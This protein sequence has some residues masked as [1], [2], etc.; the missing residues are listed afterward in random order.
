MPDVDESEP[1]LAAESSLLFVD[2][3]DGEDPEFDE[4]LAEEGSELNCWVSGS[5]SI[6]RGNNE[7]FALLICLIFPSSIRPSCI[8]VAVPARVA[9]KCKIG[10]GE[11]IRGE[12]RNGGV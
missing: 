10:A 2:E 12:R 7:R 11:A 9:M 4:L 1:E 8:M 5:T 3:D 6:A